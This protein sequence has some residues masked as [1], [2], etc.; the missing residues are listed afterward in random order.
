MNSRR[1]YNSRLLTIPFLML[2]SAAVL[3]GQTQ[4]QS[5]A[6]TQPQSKA[7][8]QPQTKAET[9]AEIKALTQPQTKAQTKTEIKA[10]TQPQTKAST[11]QLTTQTQKAIPKKTQ[12]I[13]KRTTN[14]ESF[15]GQC[16]AITENG[17]RCPR[18]ALPGSK[19][20]RQHG[21]R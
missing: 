7:Q 10:H 6:Q 5:K 21:G 17:T 1:R 8:T 14:V 18:R 19:Y 20:C 12:K 15:P 11:Q 2:I 9:K 13:E 4:E 16:Q 3:L